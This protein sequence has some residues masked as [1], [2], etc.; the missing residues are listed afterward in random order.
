MASEHRPVRGREIDELSD[1]QDRR[2]RAV[3][4]AFL[5]L[6][7]A[8]VIAVWWIQLQAQQARNDV[9]Y[10]AC[11]IQQDQARVGA[12]AARGQHERDLVVAHWHASQGHPAVAEAI[13][14]AGRAEHQIA[15]SR[16]HFA[17]LDCRELT[18]P[19]AP[20]VATKTTPTVED[21]P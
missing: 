8:A 16:E 3:I 10:A 12:I 20:S 15:V 18:P 5:A 6:T 14:A 2:W 19:P 7:V 17:R 11:L 1:R 13:L 21:M 4:R 9:F